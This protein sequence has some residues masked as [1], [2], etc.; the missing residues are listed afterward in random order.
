MKAFCMRCHRSLNEDEYC[1]CEG[2]EYSI[3]YGNVIRHGNGYKCEC[4]NV[5]LQMTLH[6]NANPKYTKNYKCL[7]CGN[8]IGI[9]TYY[10]G[11]GTEFWYD[12]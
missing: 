9:E 2:E 3:V 7:K 8:M 4:G 11:Y 10:V 6:I 5:E 1:Y 12:I